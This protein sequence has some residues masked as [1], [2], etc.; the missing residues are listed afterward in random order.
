[1]QRILNRRP[2]KG[3]DSPVNDV[4]KRTIEALSTLQETLH[5]LTPYDQQRVKAAMP[6][7][8]PEWLDGLA[9]SARPVQHEGSAYNLKPQIQAGGTDNIRSRADDTDARRRLNPDSAK[10]VL[11][12]VG[13][14]A[15][16]KSLLGH[17]LEQFL[18]WRG[19][20]IRAFRAGNKRRE[21]YEPANGQAAV[22]NEDGKEKERPAS[23]AAS[24]FDSS[25]AY[26]HLMREKVSLEAF[27]ELLDFLSADG[28][29]AIF[30]ASNAS[31]QRRAKLLERVRERNAQLPDGE[32][33]AAIFIESIVTD[34]AIVREQME[35][36]VTSSAA[37]RKLK[38]ELAPPPKAKS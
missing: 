24:F 11:I 20:N 28:Q 27:D 2:N 7:A 6:F 23:G 1:M 9:M 19:C 31:I 34:A 13:L 29:I 32:Q 37:T 18:R 12:L 5:V 14:P 30:D 22:G 15:R 35:W 25:K 17:K 16:G 33:M 26:A 36:K 38:P 4:V 21:L 10:L 8:T 3:D